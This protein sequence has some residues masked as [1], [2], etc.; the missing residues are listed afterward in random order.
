MWERIGAS[1][2]III[3]AV[4][5]FLV[6]IIVLFIME[7]SDIKAKR[8]YKKKLHLLPKVADKSKQRD[9]QSLR[10]DRNIKSK[11][12]QNAS[13]ISRDIRARKIV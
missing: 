12:R 5:L 4:V 9:K 2:G 10:S 3:G 7:H 6:F 1:S 8:K 11:L 13:E